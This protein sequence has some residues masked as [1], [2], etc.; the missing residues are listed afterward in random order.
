MLRDFGQAGTD[1]EPVS[2]ATVEAGRL[3]LIAWYEGAQDF[4]EGAVDIYLA[5]RA[6]EKRDKVNPQSSK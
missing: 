1:T 5:M 2:T 4:T 6:A 3:A